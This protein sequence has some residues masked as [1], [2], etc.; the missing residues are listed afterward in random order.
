MQP[1]CNGLNQN[2]ASKRK[3]NEPPPLIKE[4]QLKKTQVHLPFSEMKPQGGLPT[5]N[6][7]ASLENH[8]NQPGTSSIGR[9]KQKNAVPPIVT[10]DMDLIAIRK[11][12]EGANV[13]AKQYYIKFMSIGTKIL[14]QNLAY[15]N[16]IL[17][18]LTKQNKR[19]FTHDIPA[20]RTAK[21]VLSGLH[22]MPADD[23]KAALLELEIAC[24]EVKKMRTKNKGQCLY[25]VYF[26]QN[27]V[28]LNK[29]KSIKSILSVIVKWSPYIASKRGPTQCNNCQ[30]YGHG[31]RNCHLAP[32]CL[33]CAGQ[34]KK[35]NCPLS[36]ETVFIATCSLCA[37]DHVSNDLSCPKRIEYIAMR[38]SSSSRLKPQIVEPGN[39][40]QHQQSNMSNTRTILRATPTPNAATSSDTPSTS[41]VVPIRPTYAHIASQ[42]PSIAPGNNDLFTA[43]ELV[44]L[45]MALISSLAKCK[46][47]SEQFEVVSKLAFKFVYPTNG[48]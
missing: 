6:R 22:E 37:G 4:P 40:A 46:T 12:M 34:H 21:F 35:D 7:F 11:L 5:S 20:E 48:P 39:A 45:T 31:N 19:F 23:I 28:T 8:A 26:S 14:V 3:A 16:L 2:S 18:E 42:R 43:E 41:T 1:V 15:Y 33:L 10:V 13:D 24:L 27:I 47:K 36:T 17:A 9:Q 32:R 25:L 29:L 44:D 38:K 30:L